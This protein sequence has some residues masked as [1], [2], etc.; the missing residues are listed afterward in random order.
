MSQAEADAMAKGQFN[1]MAL[2]FISGDGICAGETGLQAGS[3]IKMEGLGKRFSGNY[4][5]TTATHIYDT[6]QGYR[7]CFYGKEKRVMTFPGMFQG[8]LP[9]R[10]VT[11]IDFMA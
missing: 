10:G 7:H 9:N 8:L 11:K 3:V 5:V 6:R 2:S 4:Y 1:E